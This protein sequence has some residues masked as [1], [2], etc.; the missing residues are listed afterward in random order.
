ML[1]L[2]RG[3][4][5]AIVFLAFVPPIG[6]QSFSVNGIALGSS[7]NSAAQQLSG[8]FQVQPLRLSPPLKGTQAFIAINKA[9]LAKD[10][11]VHFPPTTEEFLIQSVNGKVVLINHG[12]MPGSSARMK[13]AEVIEKLKSQYGLSGVDRAERYQPIQTFS[14]DYDRSGKLM[15][16]NPKVPSCAEH[17]L[18]FN[19]TLGKFVPNPFKMFPVEGGQVVRGCAT[20]ISTILTLDGGGTYVQRMHTVV[21]DMDAFR[22][23]FKIG[24][25]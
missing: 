8:Q 17:L 12:I 23:F 16:A 4:T 21:I 18:N 20:G 11:D 24:E 3:G 25:R 7:S 9:S 19:D 14:W 2:I 1:R 15:P 5:R 6:A 13:T 22:S 10:I